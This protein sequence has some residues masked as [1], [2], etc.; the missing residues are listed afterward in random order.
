[1]RCL[2][3]AFSFII[4]NSLLGQITFEPTFI[5]QCSKEV[6]P[7]QFWTVS[8][9]LK[10]YGF[11]NLNVKKKVLPLPKLGK[12]KLHVGFDELEIEFTI[13]K[14]GINRDTFLFQRITQSIIIGPGSEYLD[15]GVLANGKITDYYHNGKI[16]MQGVFEKGQLID[17]LFSYRKNGQRIEVFIPN[18]KGWK[19]IQ[20]FHNG[21][22]KSE[23]IKARKKK[24]TLKEYFPNG[25][26]KRKQSHKK[27]EI[28]NQNKVVVEKMKRK[29]ILIFERI[30]KRKK[31]GREKFYEYQWESFDDRGIIKRKIIFDSDHF[32]TSPFPDSVQQIDGFLFEQIVFYFNGKEFK[33]VAL[34]LVDRKS[35]SRKLVVYRKEEK[36]WVREK[37][38]SI[39]QVHKVINN[40]SN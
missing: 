12:Y 36:K 33:K 37:T 18:K 16:R 4:S 24:S 40:Y 10:T 11:K 20:Y 34:E 13:N 2:I 30:F 38:T 7:S 3:F 14:N 5:N 9:S 27:L 35:L 23:E 8:D 21:K 39:N 19:K 29:E 31:H 22:I 1:M 25:I 26:L 6:L 17:T 32:N 15:C 28:Y